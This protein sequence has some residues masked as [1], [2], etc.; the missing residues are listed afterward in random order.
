VARLPDTKEWIIIATTAATIGQQ[1]GW[2]QPLEKKSEAN[3][4]SNYSARDRLQAC[5]AERYKW[6]AR[7]LELIER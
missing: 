2:I 6:E 5:E 7:Y 4:E 3:R 1:I